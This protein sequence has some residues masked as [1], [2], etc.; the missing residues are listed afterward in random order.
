[1]EKEATLK[2]SLTEEITPTPE[3]IEKVDGRRDFVFYGDDNLFPQYISHLYYHSA[4]MESIVKGMKDYICGDGLIVSDTIKDFSN[5]VNSDYETLED[6]IEKAVFDYILFDG[7]AIQ[8][9]KDE[10]GRITEIYNLD[11]QCCRLSQD[12]KYVYYSS[13]WSKYNAKTKRIAL[14]DRE[15]TQH[16]S[17]FYFKGQMTPQSKTYP[18]PQ[19]IGALSDIRTSTEISTFHLNSIINDFNSSCIIN[20]NCGDVDD[21][22]KRRIERKFNEKFS[23]TQNA[24]KM[25]LNFNDNKETEMTVSRLQSDDFDKRYEQLSKD[26]VKNIFVAF[27]ATP[28]LFGLATDTTG[29]NSQEYAEAFNLYNRTVIRPYQ[30]SIQRAFNVM[31]GLDRAFTIKPFT[32][33]EVKTEENKEEV[34][35]EEA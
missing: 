14:Y 8:I 27:R 17:I 1:M 15:K 3:L 29:F 20:L 26:V 11:F 21:E 30:R 31:F 12:G 7:F 28:N 34:K 4:V 35:V 10:K 13:D 22:T 9:F 2:F 25:M 33:T 32:L 6:I 19:F 5:K 24:G 16:N 18:I 23:G